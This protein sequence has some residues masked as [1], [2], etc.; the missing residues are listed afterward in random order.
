M[1]VVLNKKYSFMYELLLD[2]LWQLPLQC[3]KTWAKGST[4]VY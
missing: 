2:S 1:L 4:C 3:D